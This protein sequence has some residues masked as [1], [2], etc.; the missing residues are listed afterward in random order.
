MEKPKLGIFTAQHEDFNS[1]GRLRHGKDHH[2]GHYYHGLQGGRRGNP[3]GGP[4]RTEPD[5]TG[6]VPGDKRSDAMDSAGSGHDH[7]DFI[8]M[9]KICASILTKAPHML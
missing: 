4:H 6:A 2:V 1:D 7:S 5:G 8:V 3:A 9:G